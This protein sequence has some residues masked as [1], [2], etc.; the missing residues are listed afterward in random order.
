[1]S[2]EY[3][4]VLTDDT[5]FQSLLSIEADSWKRIEE[6]CTTHKH[7]FHTPVIATV[8]DGIPTLRT[9]V[10]RKVWTAER[11]LAF[12]TDVRS[13]KIKQLG[14][15]D[16]IGWLFY[17][18]KDRIQIKLNG[19][20]SIENNSVTTKE[21]WQKTSCSSRKC[22]LA[23]QAP[24]VVSPFFTSG[25]P[26]VFEQRDPTPDESEDGYKNFAVVI[27]QV[28]SMEWLWLHHKGHRRARF[29][30][31]GSALQSQWLTP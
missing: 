17:S 30:Y 20:V 3:K 25:L 5:T 21:S 26:P 28:D 2:S 10:L 11:K 4:N 7:D 6:G 24:G 13:K 22:Y 14:V 12:H 9:V 1:M 15:N 23:E 29:D 16:A 18:S 19:S 27:T 31:T 8:S